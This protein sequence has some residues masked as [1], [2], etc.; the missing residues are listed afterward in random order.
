[1][2]LVDIIALD[3]WCVLITINKRC[4]LWCSRQSNL[5]RLIVTGNVIKIIYFNMHNESD[6]A[7]N[8]KSILQNFYLPLDC[9]KVQHIL[10]KRFLTN[11]MPSHNFWINCH[12]FERTKLRRPNNEGPHRRRENANLAVV[13]KRGIKAASSRVA[14]AVINWEIWSFALRNFS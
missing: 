9:L 2:R 5:E 14:F 3:N 4:C 10:S 8:V 11:Y 12:Q 13:I 6:A 1:M 7:I